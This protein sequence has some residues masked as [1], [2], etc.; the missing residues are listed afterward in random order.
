ME[1]EAFIKSHLAI[2][3][4]VLV[5]EIRLYLASELTP[6]WLAT[7][8][9]LAQHN[10]A[11][12]YWAFSWPGSEA[13]ARYINDNPFL[14]SGKRI[15]DFAAGCGLAGIAAA[16][17]GASAVE[18]V[19]IDPLAG[20]AVRL[21]AELNQVD[22]SIS[23]DNVIGRD[24]GWDVIIAGDVCYESAMAA[25]IV[26]WLKR[27]AECNIVLLADPGRKYSPREIG[28]ILACYEVPASLELE[29]SN[30][31]TTIIYEVSPGMDWAGQGLTPN[32]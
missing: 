27:Q 16:K 29:Q 31:K 21:N 10:M 28:R 26:P 5:P 1:R 6:L 2:G 9:F 17:A 15:L 7:E 11:P 19:E 4:S 23:L 12:P 18:A 25:T 8:S 30:K 14:V 13:L 24:G 22:I 20:E 3:R 32:R